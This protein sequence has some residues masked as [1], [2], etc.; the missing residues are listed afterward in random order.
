MAR[1]AD[2]DAAAIARP[3]SRPSRSAITTELKA[4]GAALPTTVIAATTPPDC[5]QTGLGWVALAYILVI[6]EEFTELRKSKPMLVAA[7][8]AWLLTALAWQQS[9]AIGAADI[10]RHNLLEY[11]ELLLFLLAAGLTL[12]LLAIYIGWTVQILWR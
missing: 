8:I 4:T 5:T 7:G 1:S 3:T 10:L 6:A 12:V 11:A 2:S 9:G